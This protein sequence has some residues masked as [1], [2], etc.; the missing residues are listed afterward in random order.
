MKKQLDRMQHIGLINALDILATHDLIDN[1][2]FFTDRGDNDTWAY[3]I[4]KKSIRITQAGKG[5]FEME[6]TEHE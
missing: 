4:K 1:S 3:I 6:V 2:N 5:K